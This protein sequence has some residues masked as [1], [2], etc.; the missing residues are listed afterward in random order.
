MYPKESFLSTPLQWRF[1][2][3]TKFTR[4]DLYLQ[5]T[6]YRAQGLRSTTPLDLTLSSLSISNTYLD[7]ALYH[8][9]PFIFLVLS[10]DNKLVSYSEILFLCVLVESSI[11]TFPDFR[12]FAQGTDREGHDSAARSNIQYSYSDKET[13]ENIEVVLPISKGYAHGKIAY[14]VATDASNNETANSIFENTGW[15]VNFAP[16]LTQLSNSELSQGY[17]FLNGIRGLGAFGFQLPVASSTPDDEN[18]SPLVHLN[19]VRWNENATISILKSALEIILANHKG[20][21]QIIPTNI[22][23]NSPAVIW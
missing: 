10:K 4:T 5:I 3:D 20:D 9:I 7:R 2:I 12:I 17:E 6:T 11:W 15:H 8:G 14:F 1:H 23:I 16:I 22:T 18:Y 13:G 21:L 19:L